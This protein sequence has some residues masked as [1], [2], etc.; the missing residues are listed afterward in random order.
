MKE[1]LVSS[2]YELKRLLETKLGEDLT[3]E[4]FAL[5]N[6]VEGEYKGESF[7]ISF[8]KNDY[9]VFSISN[10]KDGFAK[11]IEKI[12]SEVM[13]SIPICS[14]ELQSK[15]AKRSQAMPTIEWAIKEPEGRVKEI[16]NG[17]AFYGKTKLH[18]ITLYGKLEIKDY[19]ENEQE[20]ADRIASARIYGIDPGSIKDTKLFEKMEEID[21]YFA[22]DAMG[23]HIWRCKHDMSH[24]RIPKIDLTEEEYAL[25]YMV[26]QTTRFGVT[27]FPSPEIDEHIPRTMLYDVWYKFYD[28]H[29]K[30][31]LTDEQWNAF[32]YARK[33]DQ[34]VSSFMPVGHWQD[35]V[36][37]PSQRTK[38]SDNK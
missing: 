21:L 19:L 34:D 30:N 35:A 14:Y 33:N 20:K 7:L 15:G 4:L 28:N 11:D 22:I 26:Y 24:G 25:E 31:V 17:R 5:D 6:K 2:I 1:T 12:L 9:L 38:I 16:V 3:T 27:D 37:K 36:I 13:Q 23:G 32:Q 29:F 10:N 18:N 8:E